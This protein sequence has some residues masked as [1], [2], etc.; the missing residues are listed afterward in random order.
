MPQIVVN[1]SLI[2]SL[3]FPQLSEKSYRQIALEHAKL[4]TP[5]RYCLKSFRHAK[6]DYYQVIKFGETVKFYN[7]RKSKLIIRYADIIPY[8]NRT[9][10][11]GEYIAKTTPQAC[12]VTSMTKKIVWVFDESC[13][14]KRYLLHE[15]LHVFLNV[16]DNEMPRLKGCL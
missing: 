15:Y 6:L 4:K 5:S 2:F 3:L 13:L 8:S 10:T 11:V 16:D 7:G 9:E 14:T 1:I 12:L